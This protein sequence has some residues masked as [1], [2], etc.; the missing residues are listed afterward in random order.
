VEDVTAIDVTATA[1]LLAERVVSA[2]ELSSRR[3]CTSTGSR[4][5]TRPVKGL[6]VYQPADPAVPGDR[7]VISVG[8]KKTELIGDF[9]NGGGHWRPTGQPSRFQSMISASPQKRKAIPCSG[10]SATQQDQRD[11]AT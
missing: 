6:P 2:T 3:A 7:S 1:R 10:G 9:K 11:G 4:V 8:T 5:S